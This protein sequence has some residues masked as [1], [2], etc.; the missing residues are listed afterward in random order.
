MNLNA[1]YKDAVTAAS[2][3]CCFAL[4]V[5][6]H[7]SV[8]SV[9]SLYTLHFQFR[10]ISFTV[11]SLCHYISVNNGT[12]FVVFSGA[13]IHKAEELMRFGIDAI[14]I[15]NPAVCYRTTLFLVG[16]VISWKSNE[17][18]AIKASFLLKLCNFFLLPNFNFRCGEFDYSPPN[19][20]N[21]CL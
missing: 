15:I 12:T 5:S 16:V 6:C 19:R 2:I 4:S 7:W 3:S 21:I 8:V 11:A 9:C 10:S 14:L 17:K 20:Q 1:V 18:Q 13:D